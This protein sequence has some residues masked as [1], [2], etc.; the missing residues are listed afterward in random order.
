MKDQ[1]I[2]DIEESL[3]RLTILESQIGKSDVPDTML[4]KAFLITLS[5]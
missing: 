4:V 5:P 2:K 1:K 3:L